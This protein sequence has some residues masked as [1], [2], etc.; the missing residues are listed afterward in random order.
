MVS[1][2][3]HLRCVPVGVGGVSPANGGMNCGARRPATPTVGTTVLLRSQ[4]WI[5]FFTLCSLRSLRLILIA[6]AAF[7]SSRLCQSE[8]VDALLDL[9]QAGHQH[10]IAPVFLE[11]LLDDPGHG[12]RR[13]GRIEGE[14]VEAEPAPAKLRH[15]AARG[16]ETG[17]GEAARRCEGWTRSGEQDS[18]SWQYPLLRGLRRVVTATLPVPDIQLVAP[19]DSARPAS[20][21]SAS[22]SCCRQAPVKS[23]C[24]SPRPN[25]SGS[26][27]RW[28]RGACHRG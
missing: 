20:R 4:K 13:G 8:T 23:R 17:G 6:P 10:G 1:K 12:E 19:V 11:L 7:N 3:R 26:A 24:A 21:K 25:D 27:H 16:L 15:H 22:E 18:F 9:P 14:P 2:E 5:H 28:C